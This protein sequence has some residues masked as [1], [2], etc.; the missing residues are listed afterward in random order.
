MQGMNPYL[1]CLLALADGFITT[2]ATWEAPDKLM[3]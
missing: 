2:T 1:L 3:C